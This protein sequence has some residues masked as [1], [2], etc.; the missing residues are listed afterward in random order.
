[1]PDQGEGGSIR[2]KW[3]AWANR[4]VRNAIGMTLA[5]AGAVTAAGDIA[6][7]IEV[8]GRYL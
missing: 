2:K 5:V 8:I 6:H 4:K 7:A 1:M 3:R